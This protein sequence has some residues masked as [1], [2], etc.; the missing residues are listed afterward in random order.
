MWP[1]AS[2][3][4]LSVKWRQ[5][6]YVFQISIIALEQSLVHTVPQVFLVTAAI[7]FFSF[8]SVKTRLCGLSPPPLPPPH[9]SMLSSLYHHTATTSYKG[10]QHPLGKAHFTH[11]SW[12]LYDIYTK[13]HCFWN[14]SFFGL[15]E[16]LLS[17]S[18]FF[19]SNG[20]ILIWYVQLLCPSSNF[21][22]LEVSHMFSAISPVY[23]HVWFSVLLSVDWNCVSLQLWNSDFTTGVPLPVGFHQY[24]QVCWLP[25][26]PT[27]WLHSLIIPL[28]LVVSESLCFSR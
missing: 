2:Y 23:F 10:Q 26:P 12:L 17:F 6:Q 4:S 19:F 28:L 22:Y 27:K 21:W 5:K 24:S 25:L 18:P 15:S 8:H 13:P 20:A 7:Q 9:P 16:L 3:F 11:L 1:R 14:S